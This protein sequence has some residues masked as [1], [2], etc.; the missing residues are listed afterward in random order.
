MEE[1][2]ISEESET[3][4]EL[5]DDIGGPNDMDYDEDEEELE[6]NDNEENEDDEKDEIMPVSVIPEEIITPQS[7]PWE[8]MENIKN[9]NDNI[10]KVTKLFIPVEIQN[11]IIQLIKDK[12]IQTHKY[13]NEN[14][15]IPFNINYII[16]CAINYNDNSFSMNNENRI[17]II[18]KIKNYCENTIFQCFGANISGVRKEIYTNSLEASC[19]II[20][21]HLTS[22]KVINEYKF[23]EKSL[24]HCL[25]LIHKAIMRGVIHAGSMVGIIA[26]GSIGE[27]T[28]QLTLNTFHLS[29]V[30][31]KSGI[32]NGMETFKSLISAIKT[33]K[34]G[35][36][37]MFI[38]F[39]QDT[40]INSIKKIA[41]KFDTN[42]IEDLMESIDIFQEK[43]PF[44]S[45]SDSM[46]K[47]YLKYNKGKIPKVSI[48]SL[49]IIFN[50]KKLFDKKISISEIQQL[51]NRE[52]PYLI[53]LYSGFN[54][55]R[56]FVL[57]SEIGDC[58]LLGYFEKLRDSISNFKITGIDGIIGVDLIK[59]KKEIIGKNGKIEKVDEI[60]L[61]ASGSNL[62]D[63]LKINDI[64]HNRIYSTYIHEMAG[65]FGICVA[66][67]VTI[68]RMLDVFLSSGA[69][70]LY[71][72]LNE[73]VNTMFL[74]GI[75]SPVNIKGISET[76]ESIFQISS[77]E[78]PLSSYAD[79]AVLGKS[80]VI[81]GPSSSL[82]FG[83]NFKA[84]SGIVEIQINSNS[85]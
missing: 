28:T 38:Y 83:Q 1:D 14:L 75:I 13:K 4:E 37:Y 69:K 47:L 50:E 49:K 59:G 46:I 85:V 23:G 53:I 60:F 34:E 62:R 11:E 61:Q 39:P 19:I 66:K 51:I 32:N 9:L 18:N 40:D 81:K 31:A 29:G 30:E 76:S 5:E 63:V 72:H 8:N 16:N 12:F 41:T 44:N 22:M 84:G 21:S 42:Y 33:K 48:L 15:I 67:M 57:E 2:L 20:R 26:A 65:S 55:M 70:V 68:K 36:T 73:L 45:Q 52:Y 7:M 10:N 27:P 43:N 79:A 3:I 54:L 80:E 78:K 58:D 74:R 25:R 64:D 17:Y 82:M 71:A 35:L 24:N 6:D 77:F 56:I